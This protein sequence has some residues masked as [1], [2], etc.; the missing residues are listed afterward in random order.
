MMIQKFVE[1]DLTR[2]TPESDR[3]E[4]LPREVHH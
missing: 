3:E 2:N 4:R 1:N